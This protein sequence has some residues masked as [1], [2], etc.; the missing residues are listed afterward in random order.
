MTRTALVHYAI[1]GTATV[2]HVRVVQLRLCR[3][4]PH[5]WC[6]SS[7]MAYLRTSTFAGCGFVDTNWQKGIS[8][9][10]TFEAWGRL[11]TSTPCK[12]HQE[13]LPS[14]VL[15]KRHTLAQKPI[16]GNILARK[17]TEIVTNLNAARRQ[18]HH[19]HHRRFRTEKT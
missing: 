9:R 19:G 15:G 17:H 7:G 5:P 4:L 14:P 1:R 11:K 13:R 3:R 2:Q 6:G 16:N 8:A 18:V 10:G 12:K